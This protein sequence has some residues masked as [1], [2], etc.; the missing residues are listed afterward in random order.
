M[1]VLSLQIILYEKSLIIKLFSLKIDYKQTQGTEV[2]GTIVTPKEGKRKLGEFEIVQTFRAK[3]ENEVEAHRSKNVNLCLLD[4]VESI[5]QGKKILYKTTG[6]SK[7]N[8]NSFG[9]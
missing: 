1:N 5:P 9:S 4:S 2:N 8:P 3:H 7:E 6:G